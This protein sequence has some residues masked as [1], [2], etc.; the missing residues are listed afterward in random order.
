VIAVAIYLPLCLAGAGRALAAA[1]PEV[2]SV[3]ATRGWLLL[4]FVGY[5]GSFL[6]SAAES[7]LQFRM[8]VRRR[9]L[10]L[11]DPVVASRFFLFS[12]YGLSST[13]IL[14]ANAV[15]VLFGFNLATSLVVLAPSALLG[16]VSSAA[17]YL[18]FLPPRWYLG[19]LHP[20][21]S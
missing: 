12:V 3:A 15:A 6:W 8:A 5:A 1:A 11:A 19:R 14:L 13:G 9:A 17:I 16:L 18:A 20:R 10:G 4:C 2:D 21:A 7:M